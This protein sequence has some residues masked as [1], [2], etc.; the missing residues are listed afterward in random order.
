MLKKKIRN[1]IIRE[2][3]K[4]KN[5]GLDYTEYKQLNFYSNLQRM[6]E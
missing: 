4:I 1:N 3:I 5:S 6:N 2:K